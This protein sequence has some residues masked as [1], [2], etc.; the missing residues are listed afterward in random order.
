MTSSDYRPTLP[1]E[2]PIGFV[3]RAFAL[4]AIAVL[5]AFV[6]IRVAMYARGDANRDSPEIRTE[7]FLQSIGR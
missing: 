1:P 6:I 5:I 7:K 4:V 2:G 3:V